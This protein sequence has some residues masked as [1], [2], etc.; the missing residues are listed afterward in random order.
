MIG[1]RDS[2]NKDWFIGLVI[3]VIIVTRNIVTRNLQ[4]F[5]WNGQHFHLTHGQRLRRFT[6]GI[7]N[8][9]MGSKV[10]KEGRGDAMIGGENK[11]NAIL[12]TR[13]I[14]AKNVGAFPSSHHNSCQWTMGIENV[15]SGEKGV[16]DRD[17]IRVIIIVV[18]LIDIY[19]AKGIER[20]EF[21]NTRLCTSRSST[22]STT[23]TTLT[24]SSRNIKIGASI[25][26]L[27]RRRIANQD[28]SNV[29]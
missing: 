13:G 18:I 9:M 22:S 14:D 16:R 24:I 2:D 11:G 25:G 26:H 1:L 7:S 29:R 3:R 15:G 28:S 20:P 5:R 12:T 10:T 19:F 27:T 8:F 23:L 6:R 4:Q 17:G 21:S